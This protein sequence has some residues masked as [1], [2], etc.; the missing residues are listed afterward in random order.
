MELPHLP[1]RDDGCCIASSPPRLL[2]P[3]SSWGDRGLGPPP[4]TAPPTGAECISSPPP[5]APAV[6]G[7]VEA[8]SS[9]LD[10]RLVV[11]PPLT[12]LGGFLCF[13]TLLRRLQ[14]VATRTIT[15]QCTAMGPKKAFQSI[16]VRCR[17]LK[18]NNNINV[19]KHPL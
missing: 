8:R 4:P 13:S 10:L 14:R 18:P 17:V 2:V 15:V 5:T 1:P 16:T 6:V 12:R 11:P 9:L 3:G 7:G 19:R